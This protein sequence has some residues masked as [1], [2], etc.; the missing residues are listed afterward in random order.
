ML[1]TT[2]LLKYKNVVHR[3][4]AVSHTVQCTI[5]VLLLYQHCLESL[6]VLVWT[7]GHLLL[8]RSFP[9][10]KLIRAQDFFFTNFLVKFLSL[11]CGVSV[12][13]PNRFSLRLRACA[14]APKF[15]LPPLSRVCLCSKNFMNFLPR[16]LRF[17]TK[18]VIADRNRDDE[19]NQTNSNLGAN[20]CDLRSDTNGSMQ[21]VNEQDKANAWPIRDYIFYQTVESS[22]NA[23]AVIDKDLEG[24]DNGD[25]EENPSKIVRDQSVNYYVC[26]D[27]SQFKPKR[28]WE[29]SLGKAWAIIHFQLEANNFIL[30]PCKDR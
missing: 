19:I 16:L 9:S 17:G 25:Q 10:F 30:R 1:S 7:Y 2:Q 24:C 27:V 22:N 15:F 4:A 5:A 8:R 3:Q 23:Y 29:I 13:S 20:D 14:S 18:P 21:N 28:A 12:F 6:Q 26:K 11:R